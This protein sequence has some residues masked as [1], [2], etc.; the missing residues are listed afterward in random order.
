MSPKQALIVLSL[1]MIGLA[2]WDAALPFLWLDSTSN[3][4]L[5]REGWRLLTAHITHLNLYHVLLNVAGLWLCYGLTPD[6]FN[7]YMVLKILLLALG[8]SLFL[9][10]LSPDMLPYAGF[11]GVLYGLFILGLLPKALKKEKEAI[12]ALIVVVSWML[13]QLLTN[14]LEIEENL[15]GGEIATMAHVYGCI[16]AVFLLIFDWT[17]KRLWRIMRG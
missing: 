6:L 5:A 17:T 10:L 14:P 1:V 7:R 9:W 12:L 16:L 2:L 13:W 15:I 4:A 3:G 11:S 8:I